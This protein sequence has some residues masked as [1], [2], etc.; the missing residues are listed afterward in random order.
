VDEDAVVWWLLQWLAQ[1]LTPELVVGIV[2]VVVLV[3]AVGAVL[4]AGILLRFRRHPKL[5]RAMLR[6]R[7]EHLSSGLEAEVIDVRLHL[8]EEMADARRA[9]GSSRSAGALA[10]DL[11][12]LLDRLE[13]AAER[14]DGHLRLLERSEESRASYR[15]VRAAERQVADVVTAAR[16]IRQAAIAALGATSAGEVQGL[17]RAVE[18]EVAWVQDAVGAMDELVGPSPTRASRDPSRAGGRDR[19]G[20]LRQ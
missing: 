17:M 14:L 10:G 7:A 11:P 9:V 20:R 12:D 3:V 13:Q 19:P 18:R 6:L 2:V 16:D 4:A 1:H 8:R 15:A 5:Q